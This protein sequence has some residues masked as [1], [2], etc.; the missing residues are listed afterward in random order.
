VFHRVAVDRELDRELQ[1]YA[2]MVADE[3][4]RRND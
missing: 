1:A 3:R 4:I 2:D